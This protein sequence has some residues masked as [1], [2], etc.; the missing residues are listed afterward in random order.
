MQPYF[1]LLSLTN[2]STHFQLLLKIENGLK[3]L[4]NCLKKAISLFTNWQS[5]SDQ[6]FDFDVTCIQKISYNL[7]KI[8]KK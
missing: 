4:I 8:I 3:L 6:N 5:L 1:Q 2:N 7:H